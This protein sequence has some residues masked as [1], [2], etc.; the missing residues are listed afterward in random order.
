MH[1]V[2][3]H[4]GV[5]ALVGVLRGCVEVEL[6]QLVLLGTFRPSNKNTRY[7][8]H[9]RDSSLRNKVTRAPQY[10]CPKAL[11]K[12]ALSS[13]IVAAGHKGSDEGAS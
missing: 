9:V 7:K 6:Q 5:L 13:V 4:G 8:S 10:T 1:E 3:L 11:T 12:G 2:H